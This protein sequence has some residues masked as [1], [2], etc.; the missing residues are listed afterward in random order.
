[1]AEAVDAAFS[2]VYDWT[3]LEVQSVNFADM[4]NKLITEAVTDSATADVFMLPGQ[5]RQAWMEND[6]V[7]ATPYLP[8]E[9]G[10]PQDMIDP[11]GF[12]H[13][14]YII[15]VTTLYNT[16]S[17]PDGPPLPEEMTNPEWAG[18]IAFDRV[19]NNG[20]STL[21][22]SSF[23]SRLGD[24]A[25]FEWLD[26]LEAND[27]FITGSGGD[28][29]GA[30]LR[31][32]V[33]FGIAATNDVLAQEAGTPVAADFAS[34]PVPF[35]QNLW[36]T[37]GAANPATGTLLMNWLLSEEGQVAL[38][39]TG[40]TPVAPGVDS[41]V[42]IENILPSGVELFPA[43]ELFDYYANASEYIDILAERWPG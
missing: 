14:V 12:S 17:M 10:V 2:E 31:G 3:D 18:Q 11:E 32:E 9:A 29:Y 28:T 15:V 4:P 36:L 26:G 34:P 21:W 24:D 7:A 33:P 6:V 1:M 27:I 20:Q 8:A 23:R 38:A 37:S 39:S 25:W 13:P 30:V 22:L 41:P 19:Q 42:S 40:R 43:T 35:I 16:N 5:F